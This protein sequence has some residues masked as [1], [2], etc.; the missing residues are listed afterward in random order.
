MVYDAEIEPAPASGGAYKPEPELAP[1][2]D[3]LRAFN[4][5]FGNID[6]KDADKIR[7]IIAE[8]LPGKVAADAAYRNAMQ[9]NHRQTARIEH[10]AAR[11][12]VMLDLP[13]DH[14]GLF[15]QFSDN[16][17]FKKWLGDAIFGATYREQGGQVVAGARYGR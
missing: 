14:T 3:I 5:Q 17:S 16:P 1:L 7:R 4:D 15:K 8:G 6:W 11:Q 9:N 13:A 10:D 2:S 12:R